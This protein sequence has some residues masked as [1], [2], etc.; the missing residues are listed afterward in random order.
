[1]QLHRIRIEEFGVGAEESGV[2]SVK[3]FVDF[4][5]WEKLLPRRT[6][7]DTREKQLI[8]AFRAKRAI[9]MAGML[10]SFQPRVG[11]LRCA[12]H[13]KGELSVMFAAA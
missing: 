11:M 8:S 7:R 1:M 10:S 2:V 9:A 4:T 12:Q 3:D 13:D 6:L 5:I